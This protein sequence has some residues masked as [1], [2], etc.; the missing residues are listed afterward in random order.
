MLKKL[1]KFKPAVLFGPWSP[2]NTFHSCCTQ[3][4]QASFCDAKLLH[5][6]QGHHCNS[7][8][9]S[10]QECWMFAIMLD[11]VPF[12]SGKVLIMSCL[13]G[14]YLILICVEQQGTGDQSDLLLNMCVLYFLLKVLVHILMKDVLCDHR[15][16]ID[17]PLFKCLLSI[18]SCYK[19]WIIDKP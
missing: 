13:Q 17:L 6:L 12:F 15:N 19:V 7:K 4:P 2:S 10:D 18:S 1:T 8:A 11:V 9:E 5:D 3:A 14:Q 16:R